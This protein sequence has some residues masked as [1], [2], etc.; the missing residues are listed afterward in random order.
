MD[1]ESENSISFANIAIVEIRK[2]IPSYFEGIYE[3]GIG[4]KDLNFPLHVFS[5]NCKI[6]LIK[7]L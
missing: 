7:V 4:S 5:L 6:I 3:L 2:E 1:S